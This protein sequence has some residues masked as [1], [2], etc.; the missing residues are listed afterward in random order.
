MRHF[1]LLLLLLSPCLVS[2][3][4]RAVIQRFALLAATNDGGADRVMLRYAHS[5]A[6]SLARVLHELGGVPLS[7]QVL[8]LNASRSRFDAALKQVSV[9]LQSAKAK[10]DQVELILYYSGHAD[11]KGLLLGRDRFPYGELRQQ[12]D[13]QPADLR[14]AII[15]SCASGVLVRGKG[16]KQRPPFLLDTSSSVKGL[17]ILTSS[18][19]TEASQESDHLQASFFTHYLV[20]A[21]RGAADADTDGRITLNEAYQF[22][23]NQTLARTEQTQSGAQHPS[24]DMQL[25]GAGD[26]VLSDIRNTSATLIL[27]P[28]LQGTIYVRAKIGRLAA[29]LQKI[30]GGTVELGLQPGAYQVTMEQGGQLASANFSLA[31]HDRKVLVRRDFKVL[32]AES[33]VIRGVASGGQ[34]VTPQP[35]LENSPVETGPT[36]VWPAAIAAG[37]GG[38]A[39]ITGI[40]LGGF[41]FANYRYHLETEKI[42]DYEYIPRGGQ[43]GFL[44]ARG[45]GISA[46]SVLGGGVVVAAGGVIWQIVAGKPAEQAE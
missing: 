29:E 16:G 35:L 38:I 32:E 12:L 28:S 27:G 30:P 22:A 3:Q 42:G 7:N 31:T 5:D 45:I 33:N 46:V 18:S 37:A 1:L 26:L 8:I 19:A 11:E 2:D 17:A 21:L 23:F 10:G 24:Y 6:Q 34:E 43:D 9:M 44:A 41:S 20:T 36:I 15:D 14:I 4:A 40:V 25:A 39:I 13:A